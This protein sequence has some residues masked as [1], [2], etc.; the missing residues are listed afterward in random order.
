MKRR[1]NW[2]AE[3][4]DSRFIAYYSGKVIDEWDLFPRLGATT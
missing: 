2:I 3:L 4:E 1:K